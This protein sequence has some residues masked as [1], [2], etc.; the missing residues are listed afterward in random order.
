MFS[1]IMQMA[2]IRTQMSSWLAGMAL[3]MVLI[4]HS[5]TRVDDELA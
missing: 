5:A 2:R 1:P 3:A 4:Q